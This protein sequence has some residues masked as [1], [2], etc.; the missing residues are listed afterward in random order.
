ME[1]SDPSIEDRRERRRGRW[2]PPPESAPASAPP[3]VPPDASAGVGAEPKRRRKSRWE[4]REPAEAPSLALARSDAL[5]T[6]SSPS[7]ALVPAGALELSRGLRVQLPSAFLGEDA[8]P[9]DATPEARAAFRELAETNRR[10]LS[11]LPFDDR[12][13]RDRSPSPEPVYDRDGQRLNTRER[14]DRE[15]YAARRAELVESIVDMCPSF[16]P[17][18]DH[19]PAKK[20]RKIIIPVAEHPGYNFFGLIIGPRGNTQKRMQAETNTR[21][22]IR[23][24]GS[25]KEGHATL[26]GRYDPADDEPMHVLITGDA[27][28]DVDAAAEMVE[29]LLV[30]LDDDDNAHKRQQLR[31][32]AVINGTLRDPA[33]RAAAENGREDAGDGAGG[34]YVLPDDVRAKVDAQYRRD[35][36]RVNGEGAGGAMDTAYDDFLAELGVSNPGGGV[37]GGGVGVGVGAGAGAPREREED[38]VKVYVGRL[39]HHTTADVLTEFIANLARVRP[40]RVDVVPDRERGAPCRGFGFAVFADEETARRVA[41]AVDGALFEGRTIDARLK[42]ESRDRGAGN[43]GGR[44]VGL[45]HGAGPSFAAR[46]PEDP[47]AKLYVAHLPP[48]IGDDDLRM[49]LAPYGGARDVRVVM[50]R[51]TGASRGFAFARMADAACAR[52]A[53]EHLDGI[54][55]EGRRLAVRVATGGRNAHPHANAGFVAPNGAYYPGG[56]H[57]A[58]PN[59]P[60][61]Y[62]GAPGYHHHQH[63]QH[64]PGYPHHPAGAPLDPNAWAAAAA[65]VAANDPALAAA[66][67]AEDPWMAYYAQHAAAA[68]AAAAAAGGE[69]VYAGGYPAGA[70][71]PAPPPGA[72][73][74]DA[75]AVPP[76]IPRGDPNAAPPPPPPPA[77]VP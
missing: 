6:A 26:P 72:P 51:D 12:P 21:I 58:Y 18:P 77:D 53:I 55:L 67:A 24:R 63:Q 50:D 7:P 13:A 14:L 41:A 74:E 36:E 47:A 54:E 71:P 16:R 76:G 66:A 4:P 9:P 68:A 62:P 10:A 46:E 34:V 39:P 45:G 11:G 65:T 49:M 23:G 37:R 43:G 22:A 31:E 17:P 1:A 59:V 64:L 32:L 44:G 70:A 40:T 56:A 19:R 73:P 5:A 69:V 27:Q 48:T 57:G 3:E 33:L 30:V 8:A 52:A 28:R 61:A 20:Q 25:V 2:G 35:V 75:P 60:Y 38:N 42:S 15:R 29:K